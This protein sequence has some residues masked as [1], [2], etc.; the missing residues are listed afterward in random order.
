MLGP[1][2]PFFDKYVPINSTAGRANLVLGRG[3]LDHCEP[4]IVNLC[5]IYVNLCQIYAIQ[6]YAIRQPLNYA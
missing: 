1:K 2:K 3:W 6:I 4:I 5:Q